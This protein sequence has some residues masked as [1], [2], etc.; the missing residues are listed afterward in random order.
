M[1][2]A[3]R[4]IALVSALL[5]GTIASAQLGDRIRTM[6][7]GDSLAPPDHDTA[8]VTTYRSNLTVSLLTRYQFVDVDLER[9]EGSTLTYTTN[10]HEMYGVGISYKWLSAEALFHVPAMDD[11]DP[12]LGRTDMRG[13]GLGYTGRRLWARGFWNQAEGF[14][15]EEPERWIAD[16]RP[17]DPPVTRPD[18]MNN[19]Y[20]LSV[21][22]ALSG[23]R[24]YSQNAALFQVE[25]QKRSAGTFV[26]GVVGWVN[27]VQADS[28]LV[29][30]ALQDTFGIAVGFDRVERTIAGLTLGYT[31]TFVFWRKAFI[32]IGFIPGVAWAGQRITV[33]PGLAVEGSGGA[34]VLEL[35]AAVGWNGNRWYTSL[36]TGFFYSSAQIAEALSLATNH[37]TVRFA[38]GV[39]FGGPRSSLLQKVGL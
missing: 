32:Q 13:F 28:S 25:R 16:H 27:D 12:A 1:H 26:L 33:R 39:R 9:D 23:R 11:Y 34:G 24:R 19:T 8:Y 30:P 35:K 7:N 6:L 15:M 5:V 36:T 37:G 22:Y 29:N 2:G 4:P 18:L 3:P 10:T 21:N 31:H 38:L 14:H 20:L 17:E